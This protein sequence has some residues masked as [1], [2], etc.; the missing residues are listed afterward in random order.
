MSLISVPPVHV[1]HIFPK[2]LEN[3]YVKKTS[4]SSYCGGEEVVYGQ[5]I[6]FS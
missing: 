1:Y 4:K 6:S 2:I 3:H 5:Q